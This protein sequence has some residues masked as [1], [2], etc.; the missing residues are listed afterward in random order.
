MHIIN[1]VLAF[2]VP[3]SV[4]DTLLALIAAIL[5]WLG[6]KWHTKINNDK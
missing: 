4:M 1:I 3:Q 6:S 2:T 5:G